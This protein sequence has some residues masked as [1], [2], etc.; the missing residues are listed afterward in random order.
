MLFL[1]LGLRFRCVVIGIALCFAVSLLGLCCA[2]LLCY[3]VIVAFRCFVIG[4]LFAS[5]C[6]YCVFFFFACR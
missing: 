4:L 2:S 6:G 1:I 5:M 3:W